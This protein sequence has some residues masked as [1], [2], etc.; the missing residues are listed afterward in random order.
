MNLISNAVK[1]TERGEIVVSV[2]MRPS[3]LGTGHDL[4]LSV[5]DTGTGIDPEAQA[6]IFEPFF[7]AESPDGRIRQGTGLG[8]SITPVSYTHLDVYKRQI[9]TRTPF[10]KTSR[11]RRSPMA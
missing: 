1:Y 5:R 4:A 2:S 6:R 11:P 8:L 3:P 10:P 7:Q 9:C